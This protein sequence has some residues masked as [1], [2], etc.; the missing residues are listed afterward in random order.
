MRVLSLVIVCVVA[1]VH[2]AHAQRPGPIPHFAADV[3]G[4]YS[5]LGQDLI[6]AENL[7]VDAAGLPKRGPGGVL[8]VHAYFL[9][10]RTF[11][12]GIGAE[13]MGMRGSTTTEDAGD[14]TPGATVQQRIRSLSPQ[15]SLNFG[16]YDGWSYLTA[17]MGPMTFRTYFDPAPSDSAPS[18]MTISMGGGA[19]WFFS[20]H[21]AFTVDARFYQT[22][23]EVQTPAYPGRQRTRLLV[24]SA[25]IGIR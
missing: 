7:G 2:I 12:I 19:R 25:G 9:R 20:N 18:K 4:F 3:R 21:L 6:T 17:G 5:G 15:V 13:F 11:A 22:R 16:T 1:S 24:L 10:K 8:G 23:P 14:G